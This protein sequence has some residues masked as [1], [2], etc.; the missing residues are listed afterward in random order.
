MEEDGDGEDLTPFWVQSSTNLRRVDRLR[1]GVAAVFFSSGLVVFLLLVT[2]VL[3]LVFVVPSTISFSVSIFRPN[4]VKKSWDSLNIVLV[5]VAVVFGFLSRNRNEERS[6]SYDEFQPAPIKENESRK[7]NPST[8]TKWYSSSTNDEQKSNLSPSNQWY[9]YRDYQPKFEQKKSTLRRSSSSYPDLRDF[10]STDWNYGDYQRR[11]FDDFHV[12]SSPWQQQQQQLHHRRHRSLE[13]VYYLTTKTV[14]VDTLVSKST[15]DTNLPVTLSSPPRTA[16]LAA[17]PAEDEEIEKKVIN[18]SAA[19]RKERSSRRFYKDLESMNAP[20]PPLP[21]AEESAPPEFQ[22]TQ[23]RS[24]DRASRKKERPGRRQNKDMEPTNPITTPPPKPPPPPPPAPPPPPQQQKSSKSERKGGGAT[25]NPTKDFL[26][27]LYNKKKKQRQKSVDNMD[28][29]LHEAQPPLSFQIPPPSPPPPPPSV[30]HNLFSSKKQKRKRTITVTLEPRPSSPPPAPPRA[31]A[32]E[33]EHTSQ[34]AALPTRKR[35]KPVKMS[36]I[37]RLDE[38]S[39]SGG[40]SPLNRIPPP[41]PPPP[42]SFLKSPAWRFVVQGDYVRVNSSNSSRSGSPDLDEADSDVTP[43]ASDG[44]DV[45]AF[46]PSP[47]FCPSPDVDTKAESFITN[48]RAKLK[49]E[50][51]HSMKKRDV[52]PSSLGPGPN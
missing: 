15:E 29:L 28:S 27:S 38:T 3:F 7:S 47:L 32:R 46:H 34:A 2:A 40:E 51:I 26:N 19:V 14:I 45:A 21:P 9:E 20:K 12:D 41:P 16:V 36:I 39:N 37:D 33:L 4:S 44:G 48:F 52:G 17:S 22:D 25:G 50:K 30:F 6:S 49:L 24:N 23:R 11:F 43:T 13:Q 5:L 8:P 18:D 10:S 1:R 42:P 35:P 31:E